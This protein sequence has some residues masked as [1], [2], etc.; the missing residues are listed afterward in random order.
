ME[1]A[2]VTKLR[3]LV[4]FLALSVVVGTVLVAPT[5]HAMLVDQASPAVAVAINGL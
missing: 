1:D 3:L 5:I 4:L 2:K